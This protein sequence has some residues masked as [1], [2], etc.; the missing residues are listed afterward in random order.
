MAD[1]KA[2]FKRH[3]EQF[4]DIIL[5]DGDGN[6]ASADD[7]TIIYAACIIAEA[8]RMELDDAEAEIKVPKI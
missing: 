5:K 1:A 6:K 2:L 8:I 3:I 4:T 7:R